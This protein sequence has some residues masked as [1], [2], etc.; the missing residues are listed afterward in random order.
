MAQLPL[1]LSFDKR[2][3]FQNY[4]SE[5]SAFV[6]QSLI[7]LFDETGEPLVGLWGGADCGKTHLM[8][9]CAHYARHCHVPFHLFDALQLVDAD[10]NSFS[11]FPDGS[12]IGVDNIDLLA[13]NRSWEERFYQLI[14][15]VKAGELRFVFSLSRNPRDIGFRLPDLKSRLMWGLLIALP[16][17]DDGQ[18]VKVL[19]TRAQLLGLKLSDEVIAY[20]LSHYSR[21]LSE[22]MSLLYLL[23]QASLSKKRKITIPLIRETC[24]PSL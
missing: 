18:L 17:T 12:V 9:A 2:F 3:S 8:N 22:Q 23:D 10:A 13:G 6:S 1:P 19:K 21:K 4:V 20:L 24:A 14:N 7:A 5:Q 16:S 15:R 11:G